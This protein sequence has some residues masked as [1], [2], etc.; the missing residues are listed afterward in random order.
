MYDQYRYMIPYEIQTMASI[1]CQT[2]TVAL[3]PPNIVATSM[4]LS[5]TS[6]S[7]PWAGITA[8]VTWTNT[9]GTAGILVPGITVDGGV[10]KTLVGETLAAGASVTRSI[11]TGALALGTHTI[12]PTPNP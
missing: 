9:G 4:T 10:P 1:P 2:V 8:T 3:T 11:S 6:C 7:Y 12:C 5:A